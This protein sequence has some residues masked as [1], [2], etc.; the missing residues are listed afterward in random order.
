MGHKK[1]TILLFAKDDPAKPGEV[2]FTM[3]GFGVSGET[4]ECKK[5]D[6]GEPMYDD[7]PHKITFELVNE[8]SVNGLRFIDEDE[9]MWVGRKGE[10]DDCPSEGSKQK[11]VVKVVDVHDDGDRLVVK[12]YNKKS[13]E[14]GYKFALN[15]VDDSG[16]A[17]CFDPIWEERNGGS[18]R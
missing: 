5:D 4:I 1:R 2:A 13:D 14:G 7:E 9:V 12:N 18:S 3:S 16:K 10:L 11:H 15:F 17:H 8:S 6:P